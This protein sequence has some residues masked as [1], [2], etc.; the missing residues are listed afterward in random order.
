[1]KKTKNT[2]FVISVIIICSILF[3]VFFYVTNGKINSVLSSDA[4]LSIL[5]EQF[6]SAFLL[7]SVIAVL[8]DKNNVVLWENLIHLKLIEPIGFNLTDLSIFKSLTLLLIVCNVL[9]VPTNSSW[10]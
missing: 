10:E 4:G 1:M 7:I 9:P 5:I 3:G 2:I 6:A 8:S